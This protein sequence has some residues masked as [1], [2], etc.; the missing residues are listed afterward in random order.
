MDAARRSGLREGAPAGFR[1]AVMLF[2]AA[3]HPRD[4]AMKKLIAASLTAL[5]VS[6]PAAAYAQSWDANQVVASIAGYHF[7]KAAENADDMASIQ[8]VRISTLAGAE[9]VADRLEVARDIKAQDI[10]YLQGQLWQ[11]FSARFA[12][13]GAGVSID[14]IVAI[15]S[16]DHREGVIYADDL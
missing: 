10:R 1:H 9:A 16:V 13:R 5:A 4:S 14:Q 11:N 6:L 3:I 2:Y 8:V 7:L 12:I 15:Y